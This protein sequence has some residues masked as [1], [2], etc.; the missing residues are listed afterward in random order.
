MKRLWRWLGGIDTARRGAVPAG[1]LFHPAVLLTLVLLVLNDRVWKAAYG[2][3]WTGKLSD[4]CGLACFPLVVTAACDAA[5]WVV[6][7]VGAPI[8]F[9]LRRWKLAA[10][11]GATAVG[12][13][14]IKLSPEAG[15]RVARWLHG[16]I[17]PDR[18][19]LLALP[20]LAI[21]WWIGTR[22]LA[23]CPL[24]RVEYL[25]KRLA[26]GRSIDRELDD[27]PESADLQ[28]ALVAEDDDAINRALS[29]LRR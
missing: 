29:T 25:K 6:A 22:E 1:E 3:W 16:T 10:A 7:K 15:A 24:G 20:A 23:R 5:A 11:I 19:D 17:A 28:A 18:T 2:S 21:A 9:T 14:A 27:V 13:V 4:V 26:R 8:D 12:F